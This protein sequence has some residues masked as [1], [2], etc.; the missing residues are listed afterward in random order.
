MRTAAELKVGEKV[1]ISDIDESHP[2]HKR[3][4]EIGF[5]PGQQ[6]ELINK[7]IFNDPVAFSI[8][9]SLVAMRRSEADC[10]LIK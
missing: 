5:T 7:S 3:L 1:F 8:R 6:I 10:I 4:I 9:G 2:S